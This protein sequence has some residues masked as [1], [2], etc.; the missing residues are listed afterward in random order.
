MRN[1]NRRT[2]TD[3][4]Y[5]ATVVMNE[6]DLTICRDN[7]RFDEWNV[8]GAHLMNLSV[9]QVDEACPSGAFL[10]VSSCRHDTPRPLISVCSVFAPRRSKRVP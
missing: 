5:F 1:L 8:G 7:K 9:P 2:Q 10:R 4:N 3:K 6:P